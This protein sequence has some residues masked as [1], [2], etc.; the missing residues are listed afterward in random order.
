MNPIIILSRDHLAEVVEQHLQMYGPACDL[1]H[2]DISRVTSLDG[3]FYKSEFNGDVSRW[4]TSNVCSLKNTFERSKFNGDIS[5]WN[6]SNVQSM[7]TCFSQSAFNGDISRWDT[8]KVADMVYLFSGTRFQGDISKWNTSKVEYMNN[9]FS[10]SRFNG[11]ISGWDT[12]HVIGMTNMFSGSRFNGDI[13]QWN[14]SNVRSMFRMFSGSRFEGDISQWDVSN[15]KSMQRI[16]YRDPKYGCE[17]PPYRGELPWSLH[18]DCDVRSAFSEYHPSILGIAAALTRHFS[19][20]PFPELHES[21]ILG[22]RFKE[23]RAVA[24]VL[25]TTLVQAAQFIY[26]QLSALRS[27]SSLLYHPKGLSEDIPDMSLQGIF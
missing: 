12:S 23:A 2:L 5:K 25:N 21:T 26:Q 3:I 16:Y 17:A 19:Q 10:D 7:D 9:L 14:T 6:T 24:E 22:Q 27:E 18:P 15:V 20:T 11:D 4:D 1:N 8:S 13:S